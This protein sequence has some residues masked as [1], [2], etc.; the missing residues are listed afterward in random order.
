MPERPPLYADVRFR[1]NQLKG[2]L[3]TL[4]GT[5]MLDF[6]RALELGQ[7]KKARTA[8]Q[9]VLRHFPTPEHRCHNLARARSSEH[10]L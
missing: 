9:D 6:Q 3:D 2:E 1:M 5:L 7:R 10:A 4:C 8:L